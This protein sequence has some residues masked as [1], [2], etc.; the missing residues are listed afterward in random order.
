MKTAFIAIASVVFVASGYARNPEDFGRL[1]SL[2][3]SVHGSTV[4]IIEHGDAASVL[5]RS[6]RPAEGG[7]PGY[8]IRIFFDNGQNARTEA[9]DAVARFRSAYPDVPVYMSYENPYFMVTA[10]NCMNI[11][12]ALILWGR[13]KN[14][15]VKA[16]PMRQNIP[17]DE[18]CK[19]I[20]PPDSLAVE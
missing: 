3:D 7:V 1:L 12:E 11:E 18:F 10:G 6:L 8:R 9:V 2:P 15:F 5:A 19:K 4:R 16:Y 14:T 13:I 17:L 20:E